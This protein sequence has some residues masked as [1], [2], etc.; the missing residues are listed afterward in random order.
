[1]YQKLK[2]LFPQTKEAASSRKGFLDEQLFLI[3][4]SIA[5]HPTLLCIWALVVSRFDNSGNQISRSHKYNI[6]KVF[7]RTLTF[8]KTTTP[9]KQIQ[10]TMVDKS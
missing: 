6:L 8:I 10:M 4:H 1:M 5:S 3:I 7:D 9:L 2:N